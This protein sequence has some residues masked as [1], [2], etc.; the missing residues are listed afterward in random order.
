MKAPLRMSQ[1]IGL[2]VSASSFKACAQLHRRGNPN[3]L[4]PAGSTPPS[5]SPPTHPSLCQPVQHT[6]THTLSSF[7]ETNFCEKFSAALVTNQVG[8]QEFLWSFAPPPRYSPCPSPPLTTLL[9]LQDA[10]KQ[11]GNSGSVYFLV[12]R[13]PNAVTGNHR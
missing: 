3:D 2:H 9:P 13:E 4:R 7:N 5:P 6:H 11:G 12:T 8:R 10:Y 1:Q